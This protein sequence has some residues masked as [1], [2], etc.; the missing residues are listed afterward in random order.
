LV[1]RKAVRTIAWLGLGVCAVT[2]AGCSDAPVDERMR[3]AN[4]AVNRYCDPLPNHPVPRR[5]QMRAAV[6]RI[7]TRERDDP[8]GEFRIDDSE[9]P[10]TAGDLLDSLA[11]LSRLPRCTRL[12]VELEQ[13]RSG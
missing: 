10:T 2:S 3:A 8:D 1:G 11:Q 6:D 13:A 4:E 12:E 5:A 9:E 7:A